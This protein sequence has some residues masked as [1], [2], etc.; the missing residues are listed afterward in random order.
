[1]IVL[2]AEWANYTQLLRAFAMVTVICPLSFVIS[3]LTND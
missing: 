2:N 1:L 3:R